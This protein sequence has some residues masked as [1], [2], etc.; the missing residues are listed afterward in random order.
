MKEIQNQK[1][2]KIQKKFGTNMLVNLKIKNLPLII[3]DKL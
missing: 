2:K 3:M 1:K